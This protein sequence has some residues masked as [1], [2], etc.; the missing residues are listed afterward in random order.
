MSR[1]TCP[2]RCWTWAAVTGT[3][4]AWLSTSRWTWASTPGR[5]LS[6]RLP[7][8]VDSRSIAPRGPQG[9]TLALDFAIVGARRPDQIAQCAPAGD[10]ELAPADVAELEAILAG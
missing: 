10:A 8:L 9:E 5:S 4:P 2:A 6:A 1:S 3:S 7:V